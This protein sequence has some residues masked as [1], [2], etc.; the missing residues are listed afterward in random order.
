[1]CVS[2][3]S[4][5]SEIDRSSVIE[6]YSLR[7]GENKSE[8]LYTEIDNTKRWRLPFVIDYVAK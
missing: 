3:P 7:P 8:L 6:S 2:W 5:E 1:M 4:T